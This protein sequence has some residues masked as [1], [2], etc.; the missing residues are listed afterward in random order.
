MVAVLQKKI[1][2][3][4]SRL[5]FLV[6]TAC[7]AIAVV[8]ADVFV[9]T[10]LDH[11]CNGEH[12]AVCLQIQIAQNMLEGLGRAGVMGTVAFF[13]AATVKTVKSASSFYARSTSPILIKVKF[14]S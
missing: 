4:I 6:L 8:S 9:F 14:L 13:F 11:D 12:C 5:S 7:L 10:H 3:R 1:S 2:D